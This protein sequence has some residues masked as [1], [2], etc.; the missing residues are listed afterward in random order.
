MYTKLKDVLTGKEDNFMLP[1]Y[2]QHGDH[3][4]TIPEEVERIYKSG[5]RAFCV[6]SRPHKDFAGETWWRD[7]DL[8][9]SEAEKRNMKVW[10]LDDDHFPTGHAAGHIAKYYPD[11]RRWDIAERHV[12]VMGPLNNATM[13]TNETETT[14]LLSVYA[15]KRTGENENC[16]AEERI[17]LTNNAKGKFVEFSVPEGCWRIFF[18]YKTRNFTE[19]KDYI[20]MLTKDSVRVLIDAVYEPHYEHYKKYFGNTIAG[21]FS[22]EPQFGNSWFAG[23]YSDPGMYERRL[24]LGGMA[25][26]WN[27]EVIPEMSRTLGFDAVPYLAGIWFDIGKLTPTI[28]HAYMDAVTRLYRD[29]FTRQLGKWCTEHGVEYIGHVIEDMNTHSRTGC[30]T[31][32]Y[33]RA[34]DG[35]HMSG[36][37]I[38]L[39][40][41][42]PGMSDYIH[43]ASTHGNNANPEFFDFTLAKLCSSLAHIGMDMKG[44]AMCE[45]FGAY[46]WAETGSDMKWLLDHLLVRGVNHFVPHAFSPEFPDPDSP[47]HF[48]AAGQDPQYDSFSTLMTYGNKVTHLLYGAEPVM[49]A[50]IIYDAEADWMNKPEKMMH[51]QVPAKVL[52]ENNIDFDILPIDCFTEG[53]DSRVYKAE[54]ENGMLK[55]G[56]N[57]YKVLIIP[58]AQVWPEK[59]MKSL[60]AFEKAGVK[61]LYMGIDCNKE[62]LCSKVKALFTPDIT[63]E[64]QRAMLRTCHRIDGGNDI[65]M[66]VNESTADKVQCEVSLNTLRC[67]EGACLDLLNNNIYKV[68]AENNKICLELMP[69]QSCL[70]IFGEGNG[71]GLAEKKNFTKAKKAKLSFD[72]AVADSTDL[73]VFKA[74]EKDVKSDELFSITS[75]DRMPEFSGAVRYSCK[76]DSANLPKSGNTG[77]DLGEVGI[78]CRLSVNGNDLGMRLTKPYSY[79]LTGKLK[80]GENELIIEVYNTLAHRIKDKYSSFMALPATGLT[81][82]I[83]WTEA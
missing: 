79:D 51:T 71:E 38:V 78:T 77:I 73:T 39:H 60:Y 35:Q 70:M 1:F 29:H 5:C 34:L 67:P 27:E 82:D 44:R 22:D 3:Y 12:D 25:Y 74:Y 48:G 80:E 46:G 36:M 20:D 41:L 21:F 69:N 65:Y 66:F 37:D 2:W 59:F 11:K 53:N 43:S 7:M 81:G 33:F 6:E 62:N 63:V 17:E 54:A 45:V 49:D 47:P 55:L 14:K 56:T 32:H 68:T 76:F 4:E 72:I 58:E 26:P 23:H 57:K 40:Q 10:I 42:M 64:G 50:A 16:D 18:I 13:L 75:I 83:W 30:G 8:I 19:K 15:Y 9:L 31:G 24:G 52:F 61:I 28:R